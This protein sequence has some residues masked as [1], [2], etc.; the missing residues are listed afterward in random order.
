MS[1][2]RPERLAEKLG[3]WETIA[4]EAIKQCGR[5]RPP[6]IGP[7]SSFKE[8]VTSTTDYDLRI[9]FHDHPSPLGF[10][11]LPKGTLGV[12]KVLV[13][14]G[15]EGGF[16]DEEVKLAVDFGFACMSLGPR[17]LKSDTAAI[18]ATAIVQYTFGDLGSGQKDLDK[19]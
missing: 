4:K 10:Q 2:P 11:P 6:H 17:T 7:V 1:R 3:R 8:L 16:T 12:N 13:L 9:I 18:A 15:P 5:T 14:V 19:H